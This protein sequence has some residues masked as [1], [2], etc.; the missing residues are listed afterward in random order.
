MVKPTTERVSFSTEARID[1]R[2]VVTP[3][4]ERST[5][6]HVF[7]EGEKK[8]ER[9]DVKRQRVKRRKKP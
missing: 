6:V 7:L 3:M 5:F 9:K 1:L 4:H 2:S 8:N